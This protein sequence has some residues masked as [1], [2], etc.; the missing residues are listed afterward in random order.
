MKNQK[1]NRKG[2][3]L[4]MDAPNR[5]LNFNR[6]FIYAL[7]MLYFISNN[8]QKEKPLLIHGF[9]IGAYLYGVTVKLI[10]QNQD[11]YGEFLRKIVGFS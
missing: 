9:S 6:N 7:K 8:E 11:K 10:H 1:H 4:A 5:T 2:E 3:L